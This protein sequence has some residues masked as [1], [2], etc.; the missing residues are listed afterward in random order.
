MTDPVAKPSLLPAN[1]HI[2]LSGEDALRILREIEFLLQSL[3]RISRHHYPDGDDGGAD[4]VRRARY[5]AQT[6]R[7]ID[8]QQATTR[9]ALMRRILCAS[10]DT[11]LGTDEMD[12][13]E[14][15]I[16]ALPLWRVPDECA[17]RPS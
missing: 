3:H 17:V 14:R 9:L 15:A 16:A 6:T 5:C 8:E 1:H 7:F 10:F 2:V 11:T 4:A 12:D 13:I